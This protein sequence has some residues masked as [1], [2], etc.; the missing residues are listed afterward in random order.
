MYLLPYL[1]FNIVDHNYKLHHR[2]GSNGAY[3]HVNMSDQFAMIELVKAACSKATTTICVEL[4]RKFLNV[5]IMS[6]L[7]IV[8]PQ[9]WLCE[10]NVTTNF[11]PHLDQ[12]YIVC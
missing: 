3:V 7:G 11:F 12:G 8:Y 6:T 2:G 4:F 10:E 1:A 5:E 9:Y